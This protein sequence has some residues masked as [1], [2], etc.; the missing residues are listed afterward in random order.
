M[1]LLVPLAI[2]AVTVLLPGRDRDV[3]QAAAYVGRDR[4]HGRGHV[5]RPVVGGALGPLALAAVWCAVILV[6]GLAVLHR[7]VSTL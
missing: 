1:A 3:G 2:P 7:K 6:G 4:G 5:L